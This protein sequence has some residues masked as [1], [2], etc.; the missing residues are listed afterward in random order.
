[1][2]NPNQCPTEWKLFYILL[3]SNQHI[4]TS[5]LSTAGAVSWPEEMSGNT[6]RGRETEI[7]LVKGYERC[8]TQVCRKSCFVTSLGRR[9]T[10]YIFFII[11]PFLLLFLI[12]V[13]TE[14]TKYAVLEIRCLWEENEW[15][16]ESFF[17]LCLMQLKLFLLH[18]LSLE[19]LAMK[20]FLVLFSDTS[21]TCS[22]RNLFLW[23]LNRLALVL[24]EIQ[25]ACDSRRPLKKKLDFSHTEFKYLAISIILRAS[26]L[27][28]YF[29]YYQYS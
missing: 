7:I 5:R 21:L 24:T 6:C 1:M 27:F 29:H 28:S 19:L 15:E 11:L 25:Y 20:H 8:R 22:F 3:G 10:H 18:T 2:T 13:I 16:I 4:H 26:N 14:F 12:N 9:T 23:S 17:T